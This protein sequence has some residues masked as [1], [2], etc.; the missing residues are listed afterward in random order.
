M[1][2]KAGVSRLRANDLGL[3]MWYQSMG[4]I[5]R[6][7]CMNGLLV[8]GRRCWASR[9]QSKRCTACGISSREWRLVGV[10]CL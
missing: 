6:Y 10:I 5:G 7:L 8:V 2:P 3:L 1:E 9:S 4:K